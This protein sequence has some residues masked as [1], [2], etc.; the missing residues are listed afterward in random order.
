M[1]TQFVA[2]Y[3]VSTKR[4]GASGLGLDAQR[5]AVRR[6]VAGGDLVAEFEE[7]ESGKRIDRPALDAALRECRLRGATL[8]IAK[9]DRLARNVA[10]LSRLMETGI[11][12]RAVDMPDAN[13]LMLHVMS[14]MAEHEREMISVRTKAALQAAK[15]R[16]TKLGG[17]RGTTRIEDHGDAGR[18]RSAE[19]RSARSSARAAE[20]NAVLADLRAGGVNS[21]KGLAHALNDRSISAPRGGEWS[22]GQ[23]RRV[24]GSAALG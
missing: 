21:L 15:A 22:A 5:E 9:L 14:A 3:R 24:I 12:F 16:G 1:T 17:R 6:F 2:Y 19:V 4:Q 8:V 10:F 13:R 7:V 23:V 20:I 11:D 18:R